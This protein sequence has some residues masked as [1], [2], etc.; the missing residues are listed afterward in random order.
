MTSSPPPPELP[1]DGHRDAHLP[2]GT[3]GEGHRQGRGPQPTRGPD[4]AHHAWSM[5]VQPAPIAPG[6]A[7]PADGLWT[8]DGAGPVDDCP[9]PVRAATAAR[10]AVAD[11]TAL[12]ATGLRAGHRSARGKGTAPVGGTTGAVDAPSSGGEEPVRRSARP[13]RGADR[14]MVD[15][16][17][18]N[19]NSSPTRF[20]SRRRA[21]LGSPV[22]PRHRSWQVH[23]GGRQGMAP[24]GRGAI[25]RDPPRVT[26]RA[27]CS[28]RTGTSPSR[29]VH[30]WT[31]RAWVP[32]GV[33]VVVGLLVRRLTSMCTP[34]P[35]PKE[36]LDFR[37]R[38][39]V[40]PAPRPGASR[41]R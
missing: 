9:R 7:W 40:A 33:T 2:A 1:V 32:D 14:F 16:L 41:R 38:G 20:A 30:Q 10:G 4:H 24:R 21:C 15:H 34:A 29:S 19:R 28:C 8:H 35:P 5:P 25:D 37:P 6:T 22:R 27:F 13:R 3:H 23:P 11:A 26:R 31:A 12:A 18:F 39:G 36:T 17:P